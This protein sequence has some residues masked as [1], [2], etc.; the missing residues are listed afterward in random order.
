M[1]TTTGAGQNQ[2][3]YVDYDE[4]VDFQIEKARNHIKATDI[5]TTL[6]SL[7]AAFVGYLLVF[8]VCDHWVIAGGFSDWARVSLLVALLATMGAIL[9]RRVV[10][11]LI[12]RVHPLYAARMLEKSDPKL[13]SNLLNFV[14]L[15]HSEGVA[16]S[17]VVVR[18][19]Q[20]RA[21][22]ELSNIDIDE[23]ID[24]RP[25]LRVA[26]ALLAIVVVS[27]LYIV[28]S[29]KDPFQS[30]KRALLPM[31]SIDAATETTI[32]DVTPGDD[33]VPARTLLTIEADVRGKDADRA[34]ILFTT[35]DHKYVDEAVEMHRIDADLPRFRGTLNGENGRG[36]L[37]SLH[38]SIAAGDARTREYQVDVVQP[39]T[40]RVDEVHCSFPTYMQLEERTTPGG[41]VDGWEG[42]TVTVRATANMPVKSA[43]VVLT[44]NE[45]PHAKGEE[46]AMDVVDGT[47][48]TARWKLEFRTDGTFARY[49]HIQVRTAKN[50]TDPDP[51]LHTV[52]IRPDQRPEVELVFPR[53]DLTGEHAKPANAVIPLVIQ[54]SDPDFQLRS[55]RLMAESNGEELRVP[56]L[57]DG[58]DLG[59]SFRGSYDW[60]LSRHN[61]RPG[62]R[63][64][65]WIEARDN[66][67]PTANRGVTPRLTLEIREEKSA[68]EIR[69]DLA[70][71]KKNQEDQLARA[72]DSRNQEGREELPGKEPS[73]DGSDQ[74]NED[75]GSANERPNPPDSDTGA[76]P[77]K[78]DPK[79]DEKDPND[80]ESA[81]NRGERQPKPAGNENERALEKLL[82]QQ[83]DEEREKK[84]QEN[85]RP[86]D[87]DGQDQSG[88]DS[89]PGAKPAPKKDGNKSKAG[90]EGE[91]TS[92]ETERDPQGKPTGKPNESPR[93]DGSTEKQNDPP[94]DGEKQ[95][96]KGKAGTSGESKEP[97]TGKNP[98]KPG[99][100]SK[101]G[102]PK[103]DT[104]KPDGTKNSTPK[105][106]PGD[107]PDPDQKKPEKGSKDDPNKNRTGD[108]ES[109]D[110]RNRDDGTSP[111]D[112]PGE[113]ADSSSGGEDREGRKPDEKKPNEN[114]KD[115]GGADG[116]DDKG[117]KS[118]ASDGK[119][120]DEN[121]TTDDQGNQTGTPSKSKSKSKGG[122]E[123]EGDAD[124]GDPTKPDPKG[125]SD[126][127]S[128]SDSGAEGE[129]EPAEDSPDAKKRKATGN[130]TG[131]ASGSK[132]DDPEAV[133]AK[134]DLKR[135]PGTEPGK[136]KPSEKKPSES[137]AG[138][139]N[140][141][142][143]KAQPGTSSSRDD[144]KDTKR[145]PDGKAPKEPMPRTDDP[146]SSREPNRSTEKNKIPGEPPDAGN[147]DTKP[148]KTRPEPARPSTGKEV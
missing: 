60:D 53:G 2:D 127:Q 69:Q 80:A 59:Q 25:L 146:S 61:L 55:I 7:A 93:P 116:S 79:R 44:D 107:E 71:E 66:K 148:G 136:T 140:A 115:G 1:S 77:P 68:E 22:L 10:L 62:Q 84:Q 20:K 125:R 101:D 128:D 94:R 28:L 82:Q 14:D 88:S 89:R 5:F 117:D 91:K 58:R 51:A 67:Q 34:R 135:K 114:Q 64:Q 19:M 123:T 41:N 95:K 111:P 141:D 42:A 74:P 63:V 70:A 26:Y 126:K 87:A 30:V 110:D 76:E 130:E 133:K 35:A 16:S 4:F 108:S 48:L 46:I 72:D 11:P 134:N 65:F 81:E 54:A 23:A 24:R 96:G 121:A 32:S 18:A 137:E 3:Q 75:K 38:Y 139:P 40:A 21:A 118:P 45:D 36:L 92:S 124:G 29:P 131:E 112:K 27:A 9:V 98:D 33:K 113:N 47:K 50:E 147:Q 17:P 13:Q 15:Q 138:K 97:G 6:T 86:S 119:V 143:R 8:V 57:F 102:T 120:D 122:K 129:E 39:P 109:G 73:G 100:P 132:D 56:T 12:R 78:A 106:G 104:K 144:A 83:A 145:A 105:K 43:S 85:R 90:S 31:A 49:Y 37:Q 99:D 52:R 103:D 142:Q